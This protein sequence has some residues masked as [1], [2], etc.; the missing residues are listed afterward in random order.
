MQH[1]VGIKYLSKEQIEEIIFLGREIEEKGVSVSAEGY[2]LINMFL[3]PSTRTRISFEKAGKNL[4]MIT[5]NFSSTVTSLQKGETIIDTVETLESIGYDILVV[6]TSTSSLPFYLS[7]NVKRI[8]IINAGDGYNEHPTQALLDAL[9]IYQTFH[10]LENL[11]I[12]IVGDILFS[13]VA[14]SNIYLHKKFNNRVM[15]C[16]PSTLLPKGIEKLG[17]EVGTDLDKFIDKA[18]VI[19]ALRLQ[20]ERQKGMYFPNVAEYRKFWGLTADRLKNLQIKNKK[21]IIMHPGPIN[22]DIEIDT[23]VAYSEESV[24]LE[25][26][27]RGVF[28]RMAVILKLLGLI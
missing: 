10:T 6:R 2:S 18:D 13:R 5:T 7:K 26:V 20:F 12:L 4:K 19:M 15:V 14:R 22:R 25:Q 24:I 8:R 17:V 28:V 23:Q 11:S 21:F 3:E 27:K 9:T 1:L 16:G